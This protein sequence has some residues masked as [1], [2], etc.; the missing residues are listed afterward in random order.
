MPL[1]PKR[2]P[3]SLRYCVISIPPANLHSDPVPGGHSGRLGGGGF[4]ATRLPPATPS[5]AGGQS[6]CRCN[7]RGNQSTWRYCV[8]FSSPVDRFG[9]GPTGKFAGSATRANGGS[10]C[11]ALANRSQGPASSGKSS[12]NDDRR[13]RR[14]WWA[15]RLTRRLPPPAPPASATRCQSQC[16]CNRRGNQ[17]L[18]DTVSCSAPVTFGRHSTC[19]RIRDIRRPRLLC[20]RADLLM[21]GCR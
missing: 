13:R 7:R 19:R 11:S 15:S 2:R 16:H 21:M 8:M 4:E 5:T 12:W 14:R 10:R 17:A 20:W 3:K 18:C 6:Q 9:L 1:Q